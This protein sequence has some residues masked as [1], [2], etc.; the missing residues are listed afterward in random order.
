[1]ELPAFAPQVRITAG[2]G[3]AAQKT[4]NLRRPLTLIGAKRPA[5]IVLH[6]REISDAHCVIVNTGMD[7]LLKDLRTASGTLVNKERINLALLKDGDVIVLG[8]YSIQVAVQI[9]REGAGDSG[10]G[11]KYDDPTAMPFPLT[12]GLVH[13]DQAWTVADAVVFVGRHESAEI[14]LDHEQVARRHAVL[15]RYQAGAAV[16]DLVGDNGLM[17]NAQITPQSPVYDGDR[18]TIGA[19]GLEVRAPKLSRPGESVAEL[20][21]SLES[22][23]VST[24]PPSTA[25]VPVVSVGTPS[26]STV[27]PKEGLSALDEGLDHLQHEIDDSWKRLNNWESKLL[28]EADSLNQQETDLAKRQRDLDAQDAAL[29]GRLHDV[30]RLQEQ[31]AAR[32]KELL[33]HRQMLQAEKKE[34]ELTRAACEQRDSDVA[35]RLTELSRREHVFAQRWSRLHGMKCPNCGQ[36]VGGNEP[37]P[38]DG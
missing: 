20:A 32:E 25:P 5:H 29:R 16:F 15:F 24:E 3:T 10:C 36:Q 30:A 8:S 1:M 6:D 21:R 11:L 33:K 22:A 13:T 4:W 27:G 14:R 9:P 26:S 34:L 31:L 17:I 37:D 35:R 23:V 2:I 7:I 19:F 18:I 28:R 38:S 12:I